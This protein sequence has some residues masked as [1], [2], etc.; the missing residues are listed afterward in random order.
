MLP[1]ELNVDFIRTKIDE[2]KSALFTNVSENAFKFPTCIISAI[3]VDPNGMIWFLMN[4]AGRLIPP[5]EPGFPAELLFYRKGHHFSLKVR[6]MA[7]IV[8]D[9]KMI[10]NFLGIEKEH[11]VSN[12]LLV[13]VKM[14]RADYTERTFVNAKNWLKKLWAKL[15]AFVYPIKYRKEFTINLPSAYETIPY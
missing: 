10:D 2:I 14:A 4:K 6:G 7:T 5:D 3:K 8:T 11:D 15:E 13:N 12:I 1:S 9:Q